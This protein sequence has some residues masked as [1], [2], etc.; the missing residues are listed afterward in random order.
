MVFRIAYNHDTTSPFADNFA[1]R[2]AGLRVVSSLAVNVRPQI[3]QEVFSRE[4]VKDD[5]VIDTLHSRQQFG[6][7]I[8]GQQRP[9]LAFQLSHGA[10]AVDSHHQHVTLLAGAFKVTDVSNVEKVKAAVGEHNIPPLLP[11]A[12]A[13]SRCL[14]AGNDLARQAFRMASFS[15]RAVTV[16]VPRFITTRPPA[17]FA[18]RAA[19]RKSAPAAMARVKTAPTVSPAPVTSTA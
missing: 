13:E 10:I 16:A 17:Q 14:R 3:A 15:S 12:L 11:Q 9:S 2:N 6:A 18:S 1:F 4:I 7:R 5:H 19:V 8:F